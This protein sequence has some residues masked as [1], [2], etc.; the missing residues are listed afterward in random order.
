MLEQ[1]YALGPGGGR[2]KENQGGMERQGAWLQPH[3]SASLTTTF[4]K[5]DAQP[6]FQLR[7]HLLSTQNASDRKE[8]ILG[9]L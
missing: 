2:L 8:Q 4:L 7:L 3:T 1:G 5:D 9:N 6:L